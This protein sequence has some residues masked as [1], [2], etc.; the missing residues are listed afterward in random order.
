WIL[1]KPVSRIAFVLSKLTAGVIGFLIFIIGV[2]A[3][4]AYGEI[5]LAQ[6]KPPDVLPFVGGLGLVVLP[7]LFYLTLTFMLG[8]LFDQRGPVLGI[9][10]GLMFMSFLVSSF[11]PQIKLIVPVDLQNA[12]TAL[13]QGQALSE[14]T[15]ITMAA[16]AIWSIIFT[17]V[18][19]WRFQREEF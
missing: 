8:V 1:S 2:P 12:A 5:T 3:L 4:V 14:Q 15:L 6:G 16:C 18:A 19:L 10:L 9:S 11:V 17:A 13:A 7:L